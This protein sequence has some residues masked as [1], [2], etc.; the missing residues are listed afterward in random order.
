[1]ARFSAT[2]AAVEGFRIARE[3]P[4]AILAWAVL[5]L[6]Y[7]L[8]GVGAMIGLAGPAF[9]ELMT[10][11]NTGAA[12]PE[13]LLA[14][15][16]QLAPA[17]AVLILLTIVVYAVLYAAV[18]R[19]VLRPLDAAMAYLRLGADELRQFLAFLLLGVVLFGAYMLMAL[20]LGIV[21]GVLSVATGAGGGEGGPA[22]IVGLVTFLLVIALMAGLIWLMV[23]LSLFQPLVFDTGRF[24]LAGAWRLTKGRFWGLLG[25][26]LLSFVFIIVVYILFLIVITA[27]VAVLAG[28]MAGLSQIFAP[29][30]SSFG[31]YFSPVVIIYM[32]LV[33]GLSA[34]IMALSVGV[35]ASAYRQLAPRQEVDA[36]A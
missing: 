34:L 19:A 4:M 33:S 15:F 28:G 18:F 6:V 10:G 35:S 1:M 23:K 3:R 17:Y 29:D 5:L 32:V 9:S 22:V 21:I 20:S 11:A 31:A 36:F 27:I 2:E 26:Y 24:D 25:A 14:L 12:D 30:M 8:L 16:A 13:A 7:N